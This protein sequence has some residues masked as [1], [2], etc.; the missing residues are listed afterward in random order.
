MSSTL[1]RS[2]QI[3]RYLRLVTSQKTDFGASSKCATV[4]TPSSHSKQESK[5]STGHPPTVDFKHLLKT[6]QANPLNTYLSTKPSFT[7]PQPLAAASGLTIPI[8]ITLSDIRLS[9][10][11]I[12]V[13][14]KQKGLTLVFR[15]DPLESLKVSSTFDSIP[16]VRDYLQKEIEGQLRTLLMDEVPA[17]IHRLSLRLWVSEHRTRQEEELPRENSN[18][19]VEEKVIDP[20]TFPPADPVDLSGHVL[21]ASLITSI[22]LNSNSESHSLFSQKNLLRL[23]ALAETQRTLSLA[24]PN[25]NDAVFRAWAGPTERGEH[26]SNPPV[27]PLRPQL[28]RG[29]SFVGNTS[30]TYTFSDTYG[31]GSH[32]VRPSL[33]TLGSSTTG[34]NLG[35]TRYGKAHGGRKRKH[36]IVNL[37]KRALA[38][39]D[40]LQS[41]SGEG[42]TVSG[43]TS[44]AP[45]EFDAAI[46]ATVDR[47]GELLTPPRTP[48]RPKSSFDAISPDSRPRI[49]AFANALQVDSN[50]IPPRPSKSWPPKED[51]PSPIRL[52]TSGRPRFE[53]GEHLRSS[54]N[55][56][57]KSRSGPTPSASLA[58]PETLLQSPHPR[59]A[60][61]D[62][63]ST[64]SPE[65]AWVMKIVGEIARR[66]QDEK[67]A[68]S[69]F[70]ERNEREETPPPAYGL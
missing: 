31:A 60:Y 12:L 68:N 30:T 52:E 14:S 66:V 59:L 54:K 65:H 4:G 38:A 19:A 37:R 32:L 28:S 3:S 61:P 48:E 33:P 43:T 21:D 16:F 15:N 56:E 49:P 47:D 53:A 20:L 46:Q 69:G 36:R 9:A 42:S 22:S 10:F 17:I 8:Q 34:L 44:S 64:G 51:S 50:E 29:G 7:S 41:V 1:D 57:E 55:S 40:D 23:G 13:F 27:T 70:W 24:T 35:A 5:Y 63:T 45:S 25:I 26:G 6:S 67:A 58:P 2:H 18:P 11:I 39:D 62:V